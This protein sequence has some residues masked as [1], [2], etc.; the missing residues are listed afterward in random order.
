[1]SA[2]ALVG[3]LLAGA[4]E[5]RLDEARGLSDQDR[6]VLIE[7]VRAAA[8]RHVDPR[9]PAVRATVVL[10]A[11][12]FPGMVR[13]TLSLSGPEEPRGRGTT[14]EPRGR[15]PTPARVA[16]ADLSGAPARWA[17]PL[18]AALVAL[19]MVRAPAP[20]PSPP[21]VIDGAPP[22]VTP[23][24]VAAPI[25]LAP[26]P[27][28]SAGPSIAGLSLLGG[29]V[30]TGAAGVVLG[31]M[32]TSARDQGNPLPAGPE[33]D[34]LDDRATVTGLGANVLFGVAGA[35]LIAGIVVLVTD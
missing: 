2:L 4:L 28:P 14:E 19:G 9:G 29:A 5:V 16:H 27:P 20:E 21:P 18:D 6:A 1:M 34:R 24:P 23:P 32:N 26:E 8:D 10:R 17:A 31:V 3:V 12:A 15:G 30:V 25:D 35:A 7:Q 13:V 33:R 11:L 22:L